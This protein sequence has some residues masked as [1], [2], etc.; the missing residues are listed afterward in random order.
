[1]AE[2]T[3]PSRKARAY[4]MKLVIEYWDFFERGDM[5]ML[6]NCVGYPMMEDGL[7]DHAKEDEECRPYFRLALKMVSD[8]M[9]VLY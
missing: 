5:T 8:R 1:M 6:W 9:E 2:Q 4:M 7:Y 3:R